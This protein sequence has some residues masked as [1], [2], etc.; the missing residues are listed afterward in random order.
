VLI[1][2]IE[3]LDELPVREPMVVEHPSGALFVSGFAA[4]KATLWRSVDRGKSWSLVDAEKTAGGLLGNSDVD[5]AVAPDGTLYWIN[6]TFIA[7]AR[8]GVQITVAISRDAG[9]TWS[10][11][12]ISKRRFDD[13]PWIEVAPDGTA[14][15]VWNDG[16]GVWH[17]TSRN[18]GTTWTEA[19]R[20]HPAGGSSHLAVGPGGDVAVRITPRSASGTKFDP[21]VDLIAVS[22]DRGRTW[23]KHPAPGSRE[24]SEKSAVPLR[25]WVEPIAWDA[26]GRL[27]SA[28]STPDAIWL[29]RSDDR[30]ATW[31][32]WRIEEGGPIRY[33]PYLT[34]RG[35]S[36][37]ALTWFSAE[38]DDLAAHLAAVRITDDSPNGSSV[39]TFQFRPDS[40]RRTA[41]D[42]TRF[43]RETAGEYF[44]VAFLRD[45]SVVV[46][47][48]IQHQGEKRSG[49][50][51]RRFE[52]R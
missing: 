17:M 16:S 12:L 10:W 35:K 8:E 20:V 15:I 4:T 18:Q 6:M 24:W 44:P 40:W 19:Q 42:S 45:G 29:A 32:E 25:R 13:R 46:V 51:W 5:L 34:A 38:G 21:G 7:K 43:V 14:H 39:A 27:Y 36:E 3:R 23:T 11:S 26:A 47:S 30:A 48:P 31:R 1:E 9:T 22:S 2:S 49:F 37:V 33:Y 28:W 52:W 50:T 41:P